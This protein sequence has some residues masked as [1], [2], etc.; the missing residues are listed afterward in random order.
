MRSSFLTGAGA[1]A[2]CLLVGCQDVPTQV[3]DSQAHTL[4]FVLYSEARDARAELEARGSRVSDITFDSSEG[5]VFTSSQAPGRLS[6]IMLS[7]SHATAR[8]KCSTQAGEASQAGTTACD[9]YSELKKER[10]AMIADGHQV[11]N[12]RWNWT[13]GKFE[14]GWTLEPM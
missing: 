8:T 2:I 5:W 14:F 11:S 12:V 3:G 4:S 10:D 9:L 1:L 7:A 13:L 6:R